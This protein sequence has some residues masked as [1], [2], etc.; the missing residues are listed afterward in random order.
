M[1]RQF[2]SPQWMQRYNDQASAN[3]RW[4]DNLNANA[5]AKKDLVTCACGSE[6]ERYGLCPNPKCRVWKRREP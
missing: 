2:N 1:T 5:E 3:R 6:R 4:H